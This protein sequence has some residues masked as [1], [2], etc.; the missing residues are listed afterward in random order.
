[1]L[2]DFQY[3]LKGFKHNK[4]RTFLSLLGVIIGV[5]SVIIITTI[6]QSATA[7]IKSS[8][9]SLGLDLIQVSSGFRYRRGGKSITLN[10]AFKEK[11]FNNIDNIQEIFLTYNSSGTL[12]YGDNSSNCSV[13]AIESG[14]IE[15]N[16]LEIETGESISITD[17]VEGLQK[18][19]IGSEI[20]TI[21]FPEG[22]AIGKL[23]T[24]DMNGVQFGFRVKGIL[25]DKDT[26]LG[27]S[28]TTC[29][30]PSGFY[31]KKINPNPTA[32]QMVI[33]A[34]SEDYASK[35]AEDLENYATA[36]TGAEKSLSITSMTTMI[37]K[38][39]ETLGTVA[40]LLSAIAGISLLVG[41][42]G[43]MNIMIV[44]VTER[45]K[46]I[47]I[48]KALG[49]SPRDIKMQFLVESATISVT[50]GV[51]GIIF[52]I[53]ISII[54][55]LILDWTFALNLGV[56]FGAFLFSAVVGI[57]FGYNPASR[58]AKLDPVEALSAE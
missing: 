12:S 5:T 53:I 30:V 7:N 24:F 10:E 11:V 15:A 38:T 43:I 14:Y 35:I 4:I 23:V 41:G 9:G 58:A 46:E 49:A 56:C 52:G 25:A 32:S 28:K 21:L 3:A 34:L 50:G 42:I 19:I 44:T 16:S 26:M 36:L 33:K 1:M 18:I 51:L 2:E 47:G 6:G 48:R 37:E 22:D 13:T 55:V 27:Q 17:D 20:A 8:F 40:L 29:F 54:A 57:F 45:K 31:K 39:E